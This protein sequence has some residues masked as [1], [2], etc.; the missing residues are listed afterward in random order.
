MSC[1][2]RSSVSVV[3]RRSRLSTS[4]VVCNYSR[5]LIVVVM[6][7]NFCSYF[8]RLNKRVLNTKIGLIRLV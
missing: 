8:S 7:M 6:V 2:R 5:F 1:E 4:V 3:G